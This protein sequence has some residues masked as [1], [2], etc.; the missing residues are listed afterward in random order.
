VYDFVK[1]MSITHF[2][3]PRLKELGEHIIRLARL[4]GLEAHARSVEMRMQKPSSQKG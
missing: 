4:E 1:H 2:D 3:Q